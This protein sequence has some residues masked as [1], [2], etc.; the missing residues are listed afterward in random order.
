MC[1]RWTRVLFALMIVL[2]GMAS[3]GA[4]LPQICEFS[5][6]SSATVAAGLFWDQQIADACRVESDLPAF[7]PGHNLHMLPPPRSG[8]ASCVTALGHIDPGAQRLWRPAPPV[9]S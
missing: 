1:K 9:W 7:R 2:F 3:G 6:S 4:C 8:R 5:A